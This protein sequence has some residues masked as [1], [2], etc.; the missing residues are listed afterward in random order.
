MRKFSKRQIEKSLQSSIN[1][2][3]SKRLSP[4]EKNNYKEEFNM[5]KK[6]S[7][8]PVLI[9]TFVVLAA[10][11]LFCFSYYNKNLKVDSI[12]TLDVN[13]SITLSTNPNNIV[14]NVKALNDDGEEILT[15]INVL[16]M[17]A[18]KAMDIIVDKLIEGGYLEGDGANV[19][20]TVQNNDL[21]IA[22]ELESTLTTSI[23][24][25]LDTEYIAGTVLTQVDTIRKNIDADVKTMMYDYDISYSKAIF[26][27][28]VLRKNSTLVASDL[29][30]LR[31]NEISKLINDN[32]IKIDD[33]VKYNANANIYE[34]AELKQ[35]KKSQ[36]AAEKAA[37]QAEVKL[38]KAA[39][40]LQSKI[41]NNENSEE[42]QN[43]YTTAEQI[44]TQTT[45]AVE[46]A[47]RA[48][49]E[50]SELKSK[51]NSGETNS[52]QSTNHQGNH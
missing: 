41:Q 31:I 36:D 14:V 16:D 39:E 23:N 9:P 43:K 35:L 29:A 25:K 49:E 11:F 15:D 51:S 2:M 34:S 52:N 19:L 5:E 12:I 27:R 20:L 38:Q 30:P 46:A 18:T 21:T 6:R 7:I 24:T 47:K 13:P 33:I 22:K 45:E 1:N 26:I 50:A 28:N 37:I 42:E 32:K 8:L 44:K 4:N 3:N 40:E 17:E 10:I 48:Y